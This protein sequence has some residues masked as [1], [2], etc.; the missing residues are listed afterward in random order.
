MADPA[1]PPPQEP[2]AYQGQQAVSDCRLLCHT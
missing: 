2:P 1:Y